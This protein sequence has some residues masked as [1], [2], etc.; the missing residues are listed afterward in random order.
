MVY[1]YLYCLEIDSENDLLENSLNQLSTFKL[2]TSGIIKKYKSFKKN[3]NLNDYEDFYRKY[4][5]MSDLNCDYE[6]YFPRL[7][8]NKHFSSSEIFYKSHLLKYLTRADVPAH[9]H[10]LDHLSM[11]YG[12][13]IRVPFLDIDLVSEVFEYSY[14]YHFLEG[15]NKFMLRKV[16]YSTPDSIRYKRIKNKARD[17]LEY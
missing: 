4:F 16:S 9:L 11:S 17:L 12:L 2:T 6:R 1:P 7:N 13:E 10:I 8:D 15:F 5:K 14:K 3:L